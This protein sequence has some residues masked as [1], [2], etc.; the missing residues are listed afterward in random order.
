M[1]FWHVLATFVCAYWWFFFGVA[2]AILPTVYLT[3]CDGDLMRKYAL[4]RIEISPSWDFC[5]YLMSMVRLVT[6]LRVAH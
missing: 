2:F 1:T 5:G 4:L 3:V 6:N